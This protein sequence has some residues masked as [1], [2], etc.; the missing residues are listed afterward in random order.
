MGVVCPEGTTLA[1]MTV[2]PGWYRFSTASTVAWQCPASYMTNCLGGNSSSDA[3]CV[4]GAGGPLCE[5][6]SPS[7]FLSDALGR[8]E[9]CRTANAWLGPLLVV[10]GVSVAAVVW[11]RY[12]RNLYEW[13]T[14][15]EKVCHIQRYALL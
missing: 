9:S 10:L 4:E 12:W 2:M 8:C 7:Y 3:L 14:A 1:S 13:Y 11:Y 6:C 5:V 15:N